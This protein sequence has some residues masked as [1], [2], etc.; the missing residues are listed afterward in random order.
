MLKKRILTALILIPVILFLLFT[1]SIHGFGIATALVVLFAAWEWTYF[2]ELN[3][4]KSRCWYILVIV[5]CMLGILF[6]PILWI[7]LSTT[8][9]WFCAIALMVFYV[10][11]HVRWLTSRF[12]RG[13]IGCLVL[14][15]CWAA[16]NFIRSQPDGINALLFLFILIWGSDTAAY[17]VGKKWGTNKLLP[18]ISPGKT[19]EGV[20]GALIFASI[21]AFIL[22]WAAHVPPSLWF[23]GILLSIIVVIFSIIGD[24]FESMLKRHAHLKDSGQL[25]PGHG[26]LLDRT[27]S[28]TAA[29]PIFATCAIFLSAY[30]E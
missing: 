4:F 8:F 16:L 6:I 15:P 9:W 26:G 1:L 2:I 14:A 11:G 5:L 13:L 29:A 17:F 28:L 27:D 30:L 25:L 3:H 20:Y 22:Q 24:L 18:S 19:W 21:A 7:L 12:I 23:W 10:L